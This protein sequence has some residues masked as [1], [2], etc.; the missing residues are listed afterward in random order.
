M[1]RKLISLGATAATAAAALAPSAGAQ[2][3][4]SNAP[5]LKGAYLYIDHFKPIKSTD[6]RVVLKTVDPLPR[7]YDGSIQAG[8]SID[9]V[10]HSVGSAKRGSQCYTAASQIK[11]GRV[12]AHDASGKLIKKRVKVGS[13]FTV[14]LELRDG[15]SV[16]KTLTVRQ[17]RKGD[18]TGKPLGC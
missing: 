2:A 10:S 3:T 7:R 5:V 11:D 4:A 9:G 13:T 17:E 14:T 16:T 15:G 12:P 18:D 1:H 6:L 8:I